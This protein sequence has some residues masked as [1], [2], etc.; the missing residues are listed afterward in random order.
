[1]PGYVKT[2]LLK[3]QHKSTQ[4]HQDAFEPWNQ[5]MYGAKT[6]YAGTDTEELL[7]AHPTLYLQK[8]YGT[9]LYY[10]VAVDQTTLAALNNISTTQ[11]HATTTTMGGSFLFIKLLC[12]PP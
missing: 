8:F 4:K 10:A 3:F 2:D 5:P 11:A 6:Q 7:D 1:M 9:F 12:N